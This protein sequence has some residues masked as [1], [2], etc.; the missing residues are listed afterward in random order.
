M[1][2]IK[3][4]TTPRWEQKLDSYTKA[5]NRLA[6]VVNESK[7]REL[8]GFELDSVVQRFEFTHEVAWK[9][10]LSYC[11]F[12]SPE[13]QTLGSKDSTRWAFHAGLLENGEVW[14]DMI[15]ARNTTSHTYDGDVAESIIAKIV[16]VFYPEMIKFHDVM[17]KRRTNGEMI[18]F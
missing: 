18:L 14:M 12:V 15:W 7:K 4:M 1:Q 3:I 9:L 8:N 16:D 10:M 17:E 6:E 5:L 2:K 11:K 13:E